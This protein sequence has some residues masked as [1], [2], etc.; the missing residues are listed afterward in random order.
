MPSTI[1]LL[2]LS[3][4]AAVG[5]WL[6]EPPEVMA[7][8]NW[9]PETV[10]IAESEVDG[11]C[12]RW[13]HFC[14]DGGRAGGQVCR[15][16]TYACN[17]A[18]DNYCCPLEGNCPCGEF[19]ACPTTSN[20]GKQ[21]ACCPAEEACRNVRVDCPPG[22]TRTDTVV[23]TM[24][25]KVNGEGVC[26]GIGSAQRSFTDEQNCCRFY[27]PPDECE[28]K[29]QNGKCWKVCY[30]QPGW[31]TNALIRTYSCVSTCN[32]TAPTNVSVT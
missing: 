21:C 19:Y 30:E 22:S 12:L 16:G 5:L 4:L 10:C 3:A 13:G 25:E 18:S 2:F 15:A 31:C 7:C 24:C 32:A 27:Y 9:C 1:R 11:S 14:C 8:V 28:E 6:Y 20:S 29:C 17:R 23:S 26:G